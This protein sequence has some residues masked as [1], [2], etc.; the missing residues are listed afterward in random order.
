[1]ADG[2]RLPARERSGR[3]TA[4]G[5]TARLRSELEQLEHRLNGLRATSGEP[6]G[7]KEL[8]AADLLEAAQAVELQEV[9][10]MSTERLVERGRRLRRALTRIASGGYGICETCGDRISPRR[11]S[12]LPDAVTCLPC[13][14]RLERDG[15]NRARAPRL[16]RSSVE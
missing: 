8:K 14:E 10:S 16:I 5:L 11:L 15:A 12:A 6:V 4:L 7:G 1:V 2:W 9:M 3:V 13:Q